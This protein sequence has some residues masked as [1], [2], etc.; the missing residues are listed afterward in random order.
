M[1]DNLNIQIAGGLDFPL[2]NMA[3]V[4]QSFVRQPL[5]DPTAAVLAQLHRPEIAATIQLGAEIAI[6]VG[7]RGIANLEEITRATVQGIKQLGGR[8]FIFP[9]MGSHGGATAAGQ[10]DVLAGYGITEERVGAPIRATMEAVL[11]TTMGDGTRLYMD[12]Y[13]HAADGVVLINRIK[14]HTDF[15]GAIESGIVKMMIIG[16]G[17]IQG[18]TIMHTEHGMINFAEALPPAAAVL[19]NHIPFLFGL[20]LVEDGYENTAVI[21]AILAPQLLERERKLQAQAKKMMARLYFPEID[22]LIIEQ[23]GKDISGAGMDPNVIGRGSRAAY[24]FNQPAITKIV[25]L[26]LTAKTKGN[27][28]GL[29]LADVITAHLFKQIDFEYTY[30]NVIT[31]AYLDAGAIPLV[32]KTE[33]DAIRLAVKTTPK[34]KPAK[35]RIVHIRDTL[36]LDTIAVSQVL[37]EQVETHER[38]TQIGALEAVVFEANGRLRRLPH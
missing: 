14:P 6:G 21:E 25:A 3:L 7:S 12:K 9:A 37:L 35:A 18:A 38:L 36:T 24:G 4:R 30:A 8:P 29:G 20:G 28:C 19:M 33:A 10:Q 1:F 2:P 17:K 16:M 31:S 23:I 34:V 5:V 27:A 22:V 15:K 13:A 26:D 32:M 11:V